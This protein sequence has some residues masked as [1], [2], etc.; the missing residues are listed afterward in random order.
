MPL[1]KRRKDAKSS[2]F[3]CKQL[4]S[5]IEPLADR[6]R[7]A[8][9]MPAVPATVCAP[10]GLELAPY[11][12]VL[13]WFLED[14]ESLRSVAFPYEVGAHNF[15]GVV[16]AILA[17]RVD[18]TWDALAQGRAGAIVEKI[19]SSTFVAVTD[20]RVITADP[21]D[22]LRRG[23]LGPVYAL[24]EV[25]HVR[26]RSTRGAGVRPSID[27]ATEEQDLHWMF[28]EAASQQDID[29]LAAALAERS[30]QEVTAPAMIEPRAAANSALD[31]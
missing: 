15:A 12:R 31:S 28:P 9:E 13:R 11:L 30:P 10:E 4:L 22:L 1:T 16:P 19:A 25:R 5:A 24:D 3:T 2:R 17:R 6:L 26:G 14:G 8:A 21:R 7:P 27:V 29:S 20:R 18:A 23:E